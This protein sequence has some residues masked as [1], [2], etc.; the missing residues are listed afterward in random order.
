LPGE[1]AAPEQVVREALNTGAASISYTYTE[2][3]IFLEYALD[4]MALAHKE[5]LKNG[6]V[7]NGFM[8]P[9]TV[10]IASTHLDAANVDLKAMTDD[11]YRKI[12]GARLGPVLETIEGLHRK[13]VWVEVTTLIIPG[14]NDDE[15][16]LRDI[17][18]FLVG[19]S[20]DIPWHVTGFYPTY[21][22]TDARPTPVDTLT[23][24][25][26]IGL[27]EGLRYVYQGNR[28]GSGGENTHC[29]G[30]GETVIR[31]RGFGVAANNLDTGG[32]CRNCGATIAGIFSSETAER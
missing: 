10:E 19:I 5:G 14:H 27:E 18:R 12:C 26:E 24:A 11:F 13:G 20:P 29:P 7:T 21:K 1:F 2:P 17:A 9:E 8:T 6:F 15:E 22:L 28:P 25:R 3:T 30:C 16:E 23:R 32:R 4:V 31:R